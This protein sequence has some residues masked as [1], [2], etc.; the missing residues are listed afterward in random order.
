MLDV[1]VVG[2]GTAGPAAALLLS[3]AGHRVQ[4]LERAPEPGPVGAGILL[5]P[6]GLAV[7]DR[8]GIGEVARELGAR[9][10]GARAR[11]PSGRDVLELAYADL[12]PGLSGLGI[13]RGALFAALHSE[14]HREDVPVEAGVRVVGIDRTGAGGR[15]VLVDA[16]ARRHGPFD[17]VV[18]A[19]GARSTVRELAALAARVDPYP[20]GAVWAVVPESSGAFDGMLDQVSAGTERL[21]GFLPVGR[22]SASAEEPSAVSVFWSVR[23]DR[24]EALWAGGLDAWKRE[25]LGLAPFAEPL[26]APIERL[27]DLTPAAYHDVRM[28][29]LHGDR[30]ALVGDAGHATSPQL[31]QGANLGLRDAAILTDA[32][33]DGR[34][35]ARALEAYSRARR[36]QTRFYSLASR[37]M[38]PFFQSGRRRLGPP[39]D[40]FLHPLCRF[41]PLR[42]QMLLTLA[43]L[44]SGLLRANR[45]QVP[46]PG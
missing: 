16:A 13:H 28:P 2:C 40:L 27:G 32:V 18:G 1:A 45:P 24:L 41:P 10:D 20:W 42:R 23:L 29:R 21:V 25:V 4:V 43:G 6:T 7:L 37:W 12:A 39:R 5:Q 34:D 36:G 9:I 17:L 19:D 3:R 33:G 46:G 22:R 35:L 14:L 26:L 38:T 30:I 31:G 11:T 44:K 8:L 15:P